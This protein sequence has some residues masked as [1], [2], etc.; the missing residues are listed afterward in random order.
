MISIFALNARIVLEDIAIG[1]STSSIWNDEWRLAKQ[2]SSSI[3]LKTVLDD[4]CISDSIQL[5][6]WSAEFAPSSFI[7]T[8]E[9]LELAATVDIEV[10]SWNAAEAIAVISIRIAIDILE[11]ASSIDQGVSL[12][13]GSALV[14]AKGGTV[15][16]TA[17]TNSIG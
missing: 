15:G 17:D 11:D 3:S 6:W 4:T 8:S 7:H 13:A 1:Q 5:E 14:I 9:F 16:I 12:F 2:A 10:A